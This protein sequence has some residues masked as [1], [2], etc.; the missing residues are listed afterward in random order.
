MSMRSIVDETHAQLQ[1]LADTAPSIALLSSSAAEQRLMAAERPPTQ[2]Q[3][4]LLLR[5]YAL[6]P[7]SVW[8]SLDAHDYES[9]LTLLLRMRG[10]Q[11]QLQ[12]VSEW[13]S[14]SAKA[15]PELQ[16]LVDTALTSIGA[17]PTAAASSSSSSADNAASSSAAL[18]S[19]SLRAFVAQL[20]S[21]HAALPNL[22]AEAAFARLSSP[23]ML[24]TAATS[25][26]LVA[27]A[28]LLRPDQHPSPQLHAASMATDEP[29]LALQLLDAFLESKRRQLHDV[30]WSA[31]RAL[32]T[33][34]SSGSSSLD[35]TPVL[36]HACQQVLLVLQHTLLDCAMLFASIHPS[37]N[38]HAKLVS[39]SARLEARWKATNVEQRVRDFLVQRGGATQAQATQAAQAFAF[40]SALLNSRLTSWLSSVTASLSEA[41]LQRLFR[42]FLL[43][44]T[45]SISEQGD[46]NKGRRSSQKNKRDRRSG[47]GSSTARS[48]LSLQRLRDEVLRAANFELELSDTR[49]VGNNVDDEAPQTTVVAAAHAERKTAAE[50]EGA[51]SP[52]SDK[53]RTQLQSSPESS[54]SPAAAA[55]VSPAEVVRLR[56]K[57]MLDRWDE[58]CTLLFGQRS[59]SSFD[60]GSASSPFAA[61]LSLFDA[62]L[63]APLSQFTQQLV[64]AAFARLT[65]LQKMERFLAPLQKDGEE[66]EDEDDA[67]SNNNAG[68]KQVVEESKQQDDDA[69]A[70]TSAQ[71]KARKQQSAVSES[72]EKMDDEFDLSALRRGG[73][74]KAGH[75]ASTPQ[76]HRSPPAS[77][78]APST[79]LNGAR[80]ADVQAI[81][82][83]FRRQLVQLARECRAILDCRYVSPLTAA[84]GAGSTSTSSS[85]RA[86][87]ADTG[88]RGAVEGDLQQQLLFPALS[89]FLSDELRPSLM[90]QFN[91][92]VEGLVDGL[93]RRLQDLEARVLSSVTSGSAWRS[94]RTQALV[95][96]SVFIGRVC[97][98]L[99]AHKQ[100]LSLEHMW[101]HDAA[102]ANA[103][104][105]SSN[106]N[107]TRLATSTP[108]PAAGVLSVPL[109]ATT[110]GAVALHASLSTTARL[111]FRVWTRYVAALASEELGLEL[112]RWVE[113]VLAVQRQGDKFRDAYFAA[114]LSTRNPLA[115]AA[116]GGGEP[117]G[118]SLPVQASSGVF[119]VLHLLHEHYHS[120]LGFRVR[121]DIV[122]WLVADVSAALLAV[123]EGKLLGSGAAGSKRTNLA[124]SGPAAFALQSPPSQQQHQV[125]DAEERV[126]E[127]LCPQAV[128]QLWFDMQFLFGVLRLPADNKGAAAAGTGAAA[129][130]ASSVTSDGRARFVALQQC[131]ESTCARVL[132]QIDWLASRRAFAFSARAALQRSTMLFGLLCK[133]N[134]FPP[135]PAPLPAGGAAGGMLLPPQTPAHGVSS[136]SAATPAAAG[137]MQ[138]LFPLA[139]P[140]ARIQPI[141][142]SHYPSRLPPPPS[143]SSATNAAHARG[144]SSG[145]SSFGSSHLR[146]YSSSSYSSSLPGAAA[147]GAAGGAAPS[148]SPSSTVSA[149]SLSSGFGAG[150]G[151]LSFSNLG[152]QLS[153]AQ[154][155]SSM[156]AKAIGDL[157]T[158]LLGKL[159]ASSLWGTSS[160]TKK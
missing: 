116:G 61:P 11:A 35:A 160:S 68:K 93:R 132:D 75:S 44:T 136:S 148:V 121:D 21:Y 76:H 107:K 62:V 77:S 33:F 42:P 112:T 27:L 89:R 131:F 32:L 81:V 97:H 152:A 91:A 49:G 85:S 114:L 53:Q 138:S 9:A 98:E 118:L 99:M 10:V 115:P 47:P 83:I 144:S 55:A 7:A 123:W 65:L 54:A 128:L 117:L 105:A 111:S 73:V 104:A 2:L 101:A 46:G 150:S 126:L 110:G 122:A 135:V 87:P 100:M 159:G 72:K 155:A 26:A 45:A 20:A 109:S 133:S 94:S 84:T 90:R 15:H 74:S 147:T 56:R 82:R 14:D 120:L 70:P 5:Q 137:D 95:E 134:P 39:P 67:K 140:I 17:A 37:A 23:N 43:P 139:A 38:V 29:Q 80:E 146:P 71:R 143:S 30:V 106:D 154:S 58:A 129:T 158:S 28:L 92:L 19:A 96:Q 8:A 1:S 40:P 60:D 4:L 142:A 88:A 127:K 66:E 124:A 3:L 130:A 125:D 34:S 86:G 51:S 57:R 113:D 108:R 141:S 18:L 153:L 145:G 149:A 12:S 63:F 16:R 157:G 119:R 41:L 79:D 103:A 25:D 78:A 13:P 52:S 69:A 6:A 48:C 151:G 22:V 156:H 102:T 36:V 24:S 64:G 31:E 59:S 50:G